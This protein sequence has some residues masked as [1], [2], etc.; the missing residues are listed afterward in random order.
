MLVGVAAVVVALEGV[1][2]KL[3][4]IVAVVFG[5]TRVILD[6]YVT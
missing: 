6:S 5:P 1:G 4:F 3:G 2:N